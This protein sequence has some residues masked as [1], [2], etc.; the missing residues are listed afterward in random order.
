MYEHMCTHMCRH[1]IRVKNC[2]EDFHLAGMNARALNWD[3]ICL[4]LLN[5]SLARYSWRWV[6]PIQET[7]GPS[8]ANAR[9]LQWFDKLQ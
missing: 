3:G 7:N 4:K 9:G 8:V 2:L 1:K 5:N 6:R